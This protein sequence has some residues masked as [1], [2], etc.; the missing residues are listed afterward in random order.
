MWNGFDKRGPNGSQVIQTSTSGAVGNSSNSGKNA[1]TWQQRGVDAVGFQDR[2]E[3]IHQVW[4]ALC[5]SVGSGDKIAMK[6]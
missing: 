3:V 4:W 5:T 6:A 1:V 2:F